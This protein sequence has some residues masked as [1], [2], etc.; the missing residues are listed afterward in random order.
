LRQ[1]AM[2]QDDVEAILNLASTPRI[3]QAVCATTGLRFAA[4]ARVTSERWV[5]CAAFD[6]LNF[7]LRP[8][9]EV[10]VQSTLCHEVRGC[11]RT[12]VID[13]VATN[14]VYRDHHTPRQYGFRS[15]IS[16]PIVD[17]GGE[18]FGTLCGLDPEPRMLNNPAV[19]ETFALFAD[20]VAAQLDA[21]RDLERQSRELSSERRFG[22]LREEF[23]AVLGHD[24]RNPV[25]AI[26][27]AT[28]ILQRRELDSDAAEIVRQMGAS[29]SRM[30]EL[31][32]DLLDLARGRFGG[33][34][35]IQRDPN[36]DLRGE[37]EQVMAEIEVSSGCEIRRDLEFPPVACDQARM[38]QVLSNLL[39]NALQHG[40][41][42]EPIDVLARV[43]DGTFALSVT[44]LGP[45]IVG[46]VSRSLFRPFYR[47]Q[48]GPGRQ[49]LGLGLYIASEIAK[50]HG[51]RLSF[52]SAD[53]RVTFT[54]TMPCE[55]T[56]AA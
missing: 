43:A 34:I 41:P 52:A 50:A 51:G 40:T 31:I 54:L 26:Q 9:D 29:A 23:M 12:I 46:R 2:L 36:A 53:G 21:H 28:R 38:G 1:E 4:I 19:L 14:P 49:G 22:R 25:A 6:Q 42:G 11:G 13:D 16:V 15:Y 45:P 47:G 3:L 24:L 32:R 18:F 27:A 17:R 35:P 7:G 56:A 8:G 44:N 37:F 30:D 48:S 39:S 5:T 33:G 10:N 20:L 55:T